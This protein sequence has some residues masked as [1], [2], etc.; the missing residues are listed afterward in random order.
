MQ[1]DDEGMAH[2]LKQALLD[3]RLPDELAVGS[4]RASTTLQ[5]GL[6]REHV[7]RIISARDGEDLQP[8]A[9]E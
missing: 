5:D 3:L 4:H 8:Q 2:P 9:S 6:H 7:G 1:I